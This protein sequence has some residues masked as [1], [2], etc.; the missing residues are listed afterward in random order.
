M[1][2]LHVKAF[3]HAMLN[4]VYNINLKQND[5]AARLLSA[6]HNYQVERPFFTTVPENQWRQQKQTKANKS[7]Q[8]QTCKH[9][10]KT[11]F[12]FSLNFQNIIRRSPQASP[13]KN[14]KIKS[15]VK[16]KIRDLSSSSKNFERDTYKGGRGA[17]APR[18]PLEVF[19]LTNCSDWCLNPVLFL[20]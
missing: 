17:L 11:K 3:L 6:H 19:S 2:I 13:T 15:A 4:K 14:W 5:M 20:I 10:K 9:N 8:Q 18:P 16:E 1:T 7:K 12:W